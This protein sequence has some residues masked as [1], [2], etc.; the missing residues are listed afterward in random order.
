MCGGWSF[1]VSRKCSER[2]RAFVSHS[3]PN[4]PV[5]LACVAVVPGRTTQFL[6]RTDSSPTGTPN[7]HNQLEEVQPSQ[8]KPT[9]GWQ[10]P[11]RN[12]RL[13]LQLV[14]IQPVE[15]ERGREGKGR[16]RSSS[17]FR[18]TAICDLLVVARRT[19]SKLEAC[20]RTPQDWPDEPAS[21]VPVCCVSTH[22]RERTPG[23][24]SRRLLP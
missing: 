24:Q 2:A 21:L 10:E 13:L 22:P 19:K 20:L 8:S 11:S 17:L 9:R 15:R 1:V 18:A 23:H 7:N 4:Q 3:Y 12:L 6:G 14:R 16:K 5:T